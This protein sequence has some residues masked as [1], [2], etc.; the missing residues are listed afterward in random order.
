MSVRDLRAA[1]EFASRGSWRNWLEK[2]HATEKEALLTIYKRGPRNA[3][4][5]PRDAL[6]EALSF[7]WIDGWFKPIDANRWVIRYTPRRRGS[8]WSVYNIAR[9]WKLLGEGKMTPAGI[10]K[11]PS[12]VVR[13]WEDY[14]PSPIVMDS[15]G[16]RKGEIRFADGKDYL[17]MVGSP[18]R[19]P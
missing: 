7:G 1:L 18:A 11:V 10:A 6:E 4:L 8:S 5:S 14:H 19:T 3:A 13:V 17:S 2:N 9:V 15:K 16:A 12:D